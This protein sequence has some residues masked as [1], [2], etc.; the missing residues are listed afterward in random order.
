MGFPKWRR[1]YSGLDLLFQPCRPVPGVAS[2][3]LPLRPVGPRRG[4]P[5]WPP[6]SRCGPARSGCLLPGPLPPQPPSGTAPGPRAT[7]LPAAC[8]PRGSACP[9]AA[10][11]QKRV[12]SPL[13]VTVTQLYRL[14]QIHLSD[15]F[16]HARRHRVST[17]LF[18]IAK[19]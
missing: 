7:A 19:D 10:R 12:C 14:R 4:L 17:A 8:A 16:A 15:A 11:K 1:R 3:S 6:S 18:E 5:A 13:R 9:T 2:V